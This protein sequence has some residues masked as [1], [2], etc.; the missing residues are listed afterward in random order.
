MSVAPGVE[1]PAEDERKA[2]HVVDLVR[3]VGA[4]GGDDGVASRLTRDLGE[5]LRHRVREREDEGVLR[6]APDVLRLQHPG[7]GQAEEDVRPPDDLREGARAGLHRVARLPPIHQLLAARVDHPRHVGD[8][9]V[10]ALQPHAQQQVQAGERRGARPRG[11]QP[12]LPDALAH[13]LQGVAH[14][15]PHDDR[16]PVLVVVEHRD[17]HPLAQPRLDLEALR[18]LDVLEVDPPEG[19]FEARDDVAEALR[20]LLVDLDVEYVDAGELLE[21]HRLAFHDGLGR[22]RPDGAEAEHRGPVR[23]HRDEVRAG[24]EIRRLGGVGGDG[25]AGGGDARGVGE[26]EVVLARER[27][28]GAD[29]ELARHRKAVVREGVSGE[30][31]GHLSPPAAVGGGPVYGDCRP[32]ADAPHIARSTGDGD[33]PGDRPGRRARQERLA[34]GWEGRHL[35]KAG[36]DRPCRSGCYDCPPSEALR[37]MIGHR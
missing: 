33:D 11:D 36:A 14:R 6:H 1:R 20:V 7:R 37:P 31:V 26:R 22:E 25:V 16:G 12:H 4:A 35:H 32:V 34:D 9:D 15:R 3:V 8:H 5:D 19:G 18:G 27:L 29:R 10:L 24:G 21:Q 13:Q 30:L 23:H 28:G 17:A 2:Q